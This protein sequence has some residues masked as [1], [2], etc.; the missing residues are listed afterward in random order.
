MVVTRKLARMDNKMQNKTKNKKQI[1]KCRCLIS[2]LIV[3]VSICLTGCEWKKALRDEKEPLVEFVTDELVY[4]GEINVLDISA[5][6]GGTGKEG[7]DSFSKCLDEWR[8][9]NPSIVVNEEQFEAESYNRE[10]SKRITA[11]NMPDIFIV[12]SMEAADLAASGNLLDIT[13]YIRGSKDT[14]LYNYD[15]LF[16]YTY[17]K[18]YYAIPAYAATTQ[19]ILIYNSSLWNE[20]GYDMIPETWEEYAKA[21]KYF[22][23]KQIDTV[24]FAGADKKRITDHFL[25]SFGCQ[26]TGLSWYKSVLNKEFDFESDSFKEAITDT[27]K[28]FNESGI[29]CEDYMELTNKEALERFIDGRAAAVI[30][31]YEDVKFLDNQ[32]EPEGKENMG[33]AALPHFAKLEYTHPFSDKS[34]PY[35]IAISSK[36]A[37]DP[38]KM[39]ACVDLILYLTGSEYARIL[40]DDHMLLGFTQPEEKPAGMGSVQLRLYRFMYEESIRCESYRTVMNS[41]VWNEFDDGLRKLLNSE[42]ETVDDFTMEMQSHYMVWCRK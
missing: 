5:M 42:E 25:S 21:D 41:D 2:L 20:A 17:D 8:E 9:K 30:G 28:L 18:H 23:K 12:G 33:F 22:E 16:P 11:D 6:S 10:L 35:G 4:N 37:A 7:I 34:L 1:R 29:I 13:E 19:T 39:D 32:L 38:E 31:N 36:L 15:Y 27:K 40:Q 24:V 14:T 3:A 26:Y